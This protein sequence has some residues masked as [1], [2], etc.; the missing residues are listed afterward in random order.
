LHFHESHKL[1]QFENLID[2]TNSCHSKH[3]A[4]RARF[5]NKVKRDDCDEVE[6]KPATQVVNC[7]Q[8]SVLYHLKIIIV[9]GGVENDNDVDQKHRVDY[10]VNRNVATW[11]LA[12]EHGQLQG[13]KNARDDKNDEYANIPKCFDL[14][15]RRNNPLEIMFFCGDM[16]L[17][18]LLHFRHH[19]DDPLLFLPL[20]FLLFCCFVDLLER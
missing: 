19:A 11:K 14:V 18:A 20:L 12:R 9:D 4:A 3:V 7:D 1:Y 17:K 8:I 2:A 10:I 13:C 6:S 5:E 16:C 15:F